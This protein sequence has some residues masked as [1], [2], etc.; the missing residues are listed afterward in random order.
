[1]PLPDS[2]AEGQE[3]CDKIF[4]IGWTIRDNNDEVFEEGK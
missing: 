1:M 3:S 2:V 4:R